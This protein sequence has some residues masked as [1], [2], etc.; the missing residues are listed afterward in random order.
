MLIQLSNCI[1]YLLLC[2]MLSWINWNIKPEFITCL[3]NYIIVCCNA[4]LVQSCLHSNLKPESITYFINY[5]IVS[6]TALFDAIVDTLKYKAWVHYVLIQSSNCIIHCI[7]GAI[8]HTLKS[9]ACVHNVLIQLYN[10]M[11]YPLHCWWY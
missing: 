1:S 3:L 8:L 11:L 5:L 10:C 2:L 4:L 6:Y 9:E 7:V